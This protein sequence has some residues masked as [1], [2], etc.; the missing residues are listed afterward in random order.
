MFLVVGNDQD[1]GL[2][3]CSSLKT[4]QQATRAH[5]ESDKRAGNDIRGLCHYED[6]NWCVPLERGKVIDEIVVDAGSATRDMKTR[7][8]CLAY[9]LSKAGGCAPLPFPGPQGVG[10]RANCQ[11]LKL[12]S[13]A[14]L[15]P[16][17]D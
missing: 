2:S 13:G 15:C 14:N 9:E 17:P 5:V 8:D 4:S 11:H 3:V 10:M 1:T 16:S 12:C 6:T 7:A